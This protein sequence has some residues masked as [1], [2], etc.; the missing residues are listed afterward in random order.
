MK[1]KISELIY[2]IVFFLYMATLIF[3]PSGLFYLLLSSIVYILYNSKT[4]KIAIDMTFL[5]L[6]IIII[7][8][9]INLEFNFSKEQELMAFLPIVSYLIARPNL[10]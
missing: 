7:L 3:I 2:G 5:F 1:N 6:M 8:I 9:G 4:S 10:K